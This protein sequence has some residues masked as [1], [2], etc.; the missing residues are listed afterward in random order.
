MQFERAIIEIRPRGLFELLDLAQRF[1][2]A[3]FFLLFP[4]AVVFA[5]PAVLLG[6]GLHLWLGQTWLSLLAFWLL[7]PLSSGAGILAA[8]RLVFGVPMDLRRT[9][10]LYKPMMLRNLMVAVGQ[11]LLWL[12]LVPFFAGWAMRL[13]W[14]FTPMVL[15][16]ERLEGPPLRLRRRSLHRRGGANGFALDITAVF[17]GAIILGALAVAGDFVLSDII[18]LW[19]TGGLVRDLDGSPFKLATWMLIALAA[20]PLMD[21]TWFFYYL[22]ARIRKEGWDIELGFRAAAA[23]LEG[24]LPEEAAR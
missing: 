6:H 4:L 22:N 12:P 18:S 21:L 11:R 19:D 1:Y 2:R 23:R 20:L 17:L 14:A 5:I 24:D 16:L 3:H 9:A 10:A 15:L 7:L 8:S 13:Y